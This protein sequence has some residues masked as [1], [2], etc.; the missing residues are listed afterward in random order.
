VIETRTRLVSYALA[1]LLA[2]S[3][4][5]RATKS[6]PTAADLKAAAV[7]EYVA[8]RRRQ[9]LE[10]LVGFLGIPNVAR[11]REGIGKN[12]QALQARIRRSGLEPRLL[13]AADPSASPAVFAEW[14]VPGARRTLV[15]YA[16]YDG[17]PAD[18]KQWQSDPWKPVLRSDRLDRGGK[19]IPLPARGDPIDPN[20]RIYARSSSDDKAGVIAIL[21]AF[22]ALKA[23][24]AAP[25]S[26]LKF[27]FDGEEEAGS[28]HLAEIAA[29]HKAE[30]EA[31]AWII[32]DGPV[33]QSGRPQVVFGVRGDANLDVTVYGPLRPLHSGH[34]GNWAPNP[35]MLLARLLASMKDESGRV[36]IPG[37][38]EGVQ[39]LSDTERKAIAA[40]PEAE[41]ELRREL[42]IARPDGNGRPLLE[43]IMA[44]S[45]NIN[46]IRSGDVGP[47]ARNA[48]PTFATAVLDLRMA[49]GN[50]H[51]K[52]FQRLVEFVRGQGYLVLDR[53]PTPEERRSNPRIAKITERP[54]AYNASS[55]PMD[56]PL[57]RSVIAAVQSASREPVVVLPA[58]GGSLPLSILTETLETRTIIVPIANYDNNQH[59]ENENLRIGNLWDGIEELAAVMRMGDTR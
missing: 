54:G 21:T 47:E 55:T 56:L 49:R 40:V 16:H 31:D 36:L 34:Y 43:L 38:E 11:D 12:V 32:C 7:R 14:K 8:A 24:G 13:A 9:I 3:T 22:D 5:G 25:T 52:Q 41:S 44:P 26:N 17:Q 19:E 30:L 10:D 4:A 6:S 20:W 53:E 2:P 46:G 35:A 59:A 23:A 33:H 28:P 37:W 42:G 39:P 29:A 27:F 15:F 50:D 48:I 18:P 57:S 51:R 1:A 58:M 45:L